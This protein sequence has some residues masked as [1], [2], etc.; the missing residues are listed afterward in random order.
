MFI[1]TIEVFSMSARY[2]LVELAGDEHV[3]MSRKIKNMPQATAPL[4]DCK[5]LNLRCPRNID[6]CSNNCEVIEGLSGFKV[7]KPYHNSH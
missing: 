7:C 6:C 5:D 2:L 4:D 1:V 3:P